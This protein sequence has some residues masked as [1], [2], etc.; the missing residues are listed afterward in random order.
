MGLVLVA[1]AGIGGCQPQAPPRDTSRRSAWPE[2]F[3]D[4]QC[5]KVLSVDSEAKSE[6]RW[7]GGERSST[8]GRGHADGYD[9]TI[10]PLPAQPAGFPLGAPIG[11]A[12]EKCAEAEGTWEGDKGEFTCSTPAED[13]GFRASV[14][15]ATC[16]GKL[17]EVEVRAKPASPSA[18]HEKLR[19]TLAKKYG[20]P[21]EVK[22][23][24]DEA[25]FGDEDACVADGRRFHTDEWRVE[26]GKIQLTLGKQAHVPDLLTL[27]YERTSPRRGAL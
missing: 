4:P 21:R 2:P 9:C 15:L 6:T 16:D 13:L 22:H 12:E 3:G 25:C 27:R 8:T 24:N 1:A 14:Y 7:S 5:K 26:G 18:L 19:R 17:C 10:A 23:R 11:R 20:R